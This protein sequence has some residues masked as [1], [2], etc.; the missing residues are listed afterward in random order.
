MCGKNK[1][2]KQKK[3]ENQDKVAEQSTME[4]KEDNAA[5]EHM[6]ET[7]VADQGDHAKVLIARLTIIRGNIQELLSST[8]TYRN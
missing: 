3:E 8:A 5:C 2:K 7:E 6:K 4:E 1:Q